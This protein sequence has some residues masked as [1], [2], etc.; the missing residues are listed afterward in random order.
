MVP[1]THIETVKG[2]MGGQEAAAQCTLY[3][4]RSSEGVNGRM[5][6]I[7]VDEWWNGT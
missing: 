1:Y 3:P 2:W 7:G 4:Y 5:R 6:G